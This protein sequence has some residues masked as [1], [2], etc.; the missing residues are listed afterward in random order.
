METYEAYWGRKHEEI[1]LLN[2]FLEKPLTV[3]RPASIAEIVD[4]KF[5]LAA[6]LK[7]EHA[8][9]DWTRTAIALWWTTRQGTVE[10]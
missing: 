5:R 2:D 1:Q 6:T 7:A 10:H 9:L 3:R 4:Q 8:L